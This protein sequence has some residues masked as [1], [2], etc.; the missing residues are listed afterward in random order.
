MDR[1]SFVQYEDPQM[2]PANSRGSRTSLGG[3]Q[4]RH[5]VVRVNKGQMNFVATAAVRRA[6]K[7]PTRYLKSSSN[8]WGLRFLLSAFLVGAL[9]AA[10]AGAQRCLV[11][12]ECDNGNECTEGACIR[13]SCQQTVLPGRPCGAEGVCKPGV[14]SPGGRCLLFECVSDLDCARDYTCVDRECCVSSSTFR[15]SEASEC[16]DGNDCT[17]DSCVRSACVNE[18]EEGHACGDEGALCQPGVCNAVGN[19][20]PRDC[21]EEGACPN[22]YDCEVDGRCCV[23]V[24]LRCLMDAECDDGDPCTSD[25]CVRSACRNEPTA[26]GLCASPTTTST[27]SPTVRTSPSFSPTLPASPVATVLPSR[28]PT[29]MTSPTRSPT[30]GPSSYCTGDCRGDGKV[31]VDEIVLMLNIA[32]GTERADL[33]PNGDAGEDGMVSVDEIVAA[34]NYALNGCG[35]VE[36]LLAD[37]VWP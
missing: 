11:A 12:S 32:L 31:S 21:R 33:C 7:R 5:K 24:T 16:D 13:G 25:T 35:V 19:C 8:G 22:G 20:L 30:R 10:P 4:N 34:V 2:Q 6:L 29:A 15:C 18:P 27:A 23:S 14:C 17:L 28:T 3:T 1:R 37:E 36:V 9:A 26:P